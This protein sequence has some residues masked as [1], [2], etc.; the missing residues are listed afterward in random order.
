VFA[1]IVQMKWESRHDRRFWIAIAAFAAIHIVAIVL[2]KFPTP[3]FGLLSFPFAL[4]DGFLMFGV[5]NWM[6]KRFP[7][8][9]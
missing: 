1:A 8:R 5:L 9:A 6:E 3:K 2:I 7:R 4:I